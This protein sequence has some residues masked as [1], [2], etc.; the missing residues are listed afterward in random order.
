MDIFVV[1]HAHNLQILPRQTLYVNRSYDVV[2]RHQI[3]IAL[4]SFMKTYSDTE[5]ESY[6]GQRGYDPSYIGAVELT[7]DPDVFYLPGREGETPYQ[8]RII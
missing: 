4:P 6:S 1:G 7:I 3:G 2:H 8:V 5:A